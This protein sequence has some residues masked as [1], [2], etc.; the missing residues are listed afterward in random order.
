MERMY[1]GVPSAGPTTRSMPNSRI[2]GM[3]YC[4]YQ[5]D[6]T[7]YCR[8]SRVSTPRKIIYTPIGINNN[9]AIM[10]LQTH[11][12]QPSFLATSRHGTEEDSQ[13]EGYVDASVEELHNVRISSRSC[14]S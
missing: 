7:L 6:T 9:P 13:R 8:R 3:A 14:R 2:P 10:S 11:D 12:G 5:T 1:P 4:A